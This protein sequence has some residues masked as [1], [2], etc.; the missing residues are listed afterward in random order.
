MT[1]KTAWIG[2]S[3]TDLA[4]TPEL[5]RQMLTHA[6]TSAAAALN[7]EENPVPLLAVGEVRTYVMTLQCLHTPGEA[8]VADT[9]DVT[10]T[11][12]PAPLLRM[13]RHRLE[14]TR[15]WWRFWGKK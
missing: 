5:T 1:N 9:V 6:V 12:E 2:E 10:A 15:P 11:I 8:N 14:T 7:A 3:H 13:S 4:L